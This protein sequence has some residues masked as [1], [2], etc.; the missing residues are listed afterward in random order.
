MNN[1]IYDEE[2][3]PNI[4]CIVIK[5]HESGVYNHFVIT[6][7]RNDWLQLNSF[8]TAI[9]G[10]RMIGFNNN[11]YDYPVLHY[12][13]NFGPKI[14]AADIY[15]KSVEI[16]TADKEDKWNHVIWPNDRYVEQIDLFLIH[17]FDNVAKA[18]SLKI[19]EF[20]M[21]SRQIQDLPYE[22]GKILN[23]AERQELL[24]YN[25]KDVDETEKFFEKTKKAIKF[26]EY[27]SQKYKRNFLNH[28]D[29]KIGKDYLASQIEKAASGSCYRKDSTGRRR[30]QQ[31]I[32]PYVDL[33]DVIFPYVKFE[34]PAFNAILNWFKAQRIIK[35]KGVFTD[36]PVEKIGSTLSNFCI[37]KDSKKKGCHADKLN[38]VI[39]DFRY[40]F[41]TGGLHGSIE[42]KHVK[43]T[44]E[45]ELLDVDVESFYP[46]EAIV[47]KLAPAHIGEIFCLIYSDVKTER[48]SYE[49]STPENKALKF[50][51]NGTFGDTNSPF[52]PFYDSAYTMGITI[53]G[54]LL[55]CML[56]EQAIKIPGLEMIQANTDGIT[57]LCPRQYIEHFRHVC[58]WWENYT[59]LKLEEN[60]YSD[61]WI[62]DVNNYIARY[63]KDGKL[64]RK[65]AYRY[66]YEEA[67]EWHK[68]FSQ[69]IVPK[70]AE[71]K[72]VY[73]VDIADYIRTYPD[74]YDFMLRT[75]VP[76]SSKLFLRYKDRPQRQIQ[77]I[78][79][80]YISNQGGSLIK[81]MPPLAKNPGVWREIGINVGQL[82]TE[83]NNMDDHTSFDLNY[84]YY[85][86]EADKLVQPV[87]N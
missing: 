74:I 69:L 54:Q 11:F 78:S 80:Y 83:C 77:N 52:S 38:C 6:D 40:D 4:F 5:C 62:R 19:L 1:Y 72:L 23:A 34:Q 45:K 24:K 57:V 76:R 84:D 51:L 58:K 31:T 12:I 67:E 33:K 60:I 79:R 13:L 15:K 14:T 85:I 47:N 70:A 8:I 28:N 7:I 44:D 18:T 10:Q 39:N 59:L 56:V 17:H 20:N 37:L 63:A 22:P 68:N 43:S 53:N 66:E 86:N 29:T 81:V 41:G 26:R 3:Y 16:I 48:L 21:R 71:A 65:G 49:K 9:K 50:A 25:Y 36:I 75:K 32:R 27:L 2:S 82:V 46:S 42:S 61:M 64:K 35:T 87:I 55:L 30:P 73:G